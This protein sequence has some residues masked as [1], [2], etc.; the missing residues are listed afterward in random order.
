M[1]RQHCSRCWR[2]IS[3]QGG[4]QDWSG[5]SLA[6]AEATRSKFAMMTPERAR[7]ILDL[8]LVAARLRLDAAMVDVMASFERGGV[9]ALVLKGPAVA[10]WIYSRVDER[11]YEDCDV[12]VCPDEVAAAGQ[13]LGSLG[14]ERHFDDSRMP[15]WWREHA[16]E[17]VRHSDGVT[18]DVHRRLPGVRVNDESAWAVLSAD[19]SSVL[20]AGSQLPTLA[21]PARVLHVC[22]HAAQHGAAWTKPM[23]DLKE[24]VRRTSD[25]LAL[26]L[27]AVALAEALEATERFASGLR[28]DPDG[29]RL[30]DQLGLPSE[31][32]VETK[33]RAD[34]A[35]P[36]ALTIE[37]LVAAEGA[38]A[39]AAIVWHK[40]V[41]PPSYLK[42]WDPGAAQG[43]GQM[44]RGYLRRLLW[45]A[46]STPPALR[47][48]RAARH[49]TRGRPERNEGH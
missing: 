1:R 16:E 36:Q 40:L 20:V 45:I 39:R 5:G 9:H 12:L 32:S 17:W 11:G 41:P 7:T 26:W 19:A 24:A 47:V 38:A 29:S 46:R 44:F 42:K 28:L 48:W 23:R 34:S 37:R 21:L 14:F 6:T 25:D 27:D 43:I 10:R 15:G 49:A 33:L 4:R 35:L 2:Q 31:V 22:L 3:E 18:I 30:A 8:Q 13:A